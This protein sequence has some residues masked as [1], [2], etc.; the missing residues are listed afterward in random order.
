MK[1]VVFVVIILMV[2]FIELHAQDKGFLKED[3]FISGAFRIAS[4]S[5]GDIDNS[6]F[7][8]SPRFG[9][10]ITENFALGG[11]L[12]YQHRESDN[13]ID[14]SVE[15]S[16]YGIGS[17][18]RYYFT[19]QSQFSLYVQVL[20]DY[21]RSENSASDYTFD[22]FAFG[23]GGGLNYFV[24]KKFSLEANVGFI[25]YSTTTSNEEGS[26]SRNVFNFG[27]VFSNIGIG[28]NYKF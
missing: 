18:G 4:S 19:P 23:L 13:N 6:I 26:K 2:G 12:I 3:V 14:D 7:E 9:Y 17:F 28:L 8:I 25:E 20:I 24:S 1:K 10:F 16:S 22:N 27:L 15:I 5:E 11:R 21:L